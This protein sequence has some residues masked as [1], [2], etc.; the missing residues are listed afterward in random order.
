[1]LLPFD[2]HVHTYY[3]PCGRKVDEDQQP[4]ASPQQ[5]LDRAEA[6]NLQALIFTDHFYE[7]PADPAAPQFY[8]GSDIAIIRNLQRELERLEAPSGCKIYMGCETETVSVDRVG[9]S[10][11]M[12]ASLDFVLVPTTHYHLSGIPQPKSRKPEDVADHMLTML[13]S[14][15]RQEWVDALAHPFAEKESLIGNLL[16]TYEAMDKGR[17]QDIL[18]LAAENGVALEVNGSSVTSP[19][20]PHYGDMYKEIVKR[21]K[22]LGVRFTFG[23]DAHDCHDLGMSAEAETWIRDAGLVASDFL[24]PDELQARRRWFSEGHPDKR[25]C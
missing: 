14:V 11:Q 24:T 2:T 25:P 22:A 8:K 19:D 10:P 15:V 16:R 9:I 5:Y 18:G 4:L 21:A 20:L 13:E 23:S 7:W 1:M 3:S 6:L 12:A 17:L